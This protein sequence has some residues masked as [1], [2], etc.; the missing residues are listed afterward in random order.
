MRKCVLRVYWSYSY[1]HIFSK[2]LA[3]SFK[4]FNWNFKKVSNHLNLHFHVHCVSHHSGELEIETECS[5]WC[6]S[7]V[8]AWVQKVFS[9]Y[10]VF[11]YSAF[12]FNENMFAPRASRQLFFLL[13]FEGKNKSKNVGRHLLVYLSKTKVCT[14]IIILKFRFLLCCLLKRFLFLKYPFTVFARVQKH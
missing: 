3:Q 2:C 12:V 14:N 10:F 1:L 5:G 8:P 9:I 4:F 6:F 11:W 13:P 7:Y